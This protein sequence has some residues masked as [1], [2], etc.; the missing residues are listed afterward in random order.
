[1][2]SE[3]VFKLKVV[4]RSGK[5]TI[6][7]LKEKEIFNFKKDMAGL[8]ENQKYLTENNVEIKSKDIKAYDEVK[9]LKIIDLI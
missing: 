1:M 6:L 2:K 4:Q 8:L 3:N 7:K 9:L 5:E